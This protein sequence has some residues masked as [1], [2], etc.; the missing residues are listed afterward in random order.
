MT[1]HGRALLED[2]PRVVNVGLEGFAEDLAAHGVPA[3]AAMSLNC[4]VRTS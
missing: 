2:G 1:T 3:D 4:D